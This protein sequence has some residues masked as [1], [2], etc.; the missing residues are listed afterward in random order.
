[1]IN[2]FGASP[3]RILALGFGEDRPTEENTSR[4]GRARNRRV[5]IVG[6]KTKIS[7]GF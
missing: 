3:D 1:M 2:R 4:D 6:L 5:V 7:V